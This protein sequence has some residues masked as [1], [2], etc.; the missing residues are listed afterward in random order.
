M[1]GFHHAPDEVRRASPGRSVQQGMVAGRRLVPPI[2]LPS[3]LAGHGSKSIALE[4]SDPLEVNAVLLA[5]GDRRCLLISFD[6][7]YVSGTLR[8]ELLAELAQRHGIADGDVF[9]FASHTHFAPPTDAALP[10]LGPFDEAYARRVRDAVIDL[11]D[12]LMGKRPAPFRIEAR[13]GTLA[14]SINRRRPRVFPSYTRTWGVSFARVTLAPYPQG[15]RDD[16]ATVITLADASNAPIAV[17]WHYACHP[18]GHAPSQATSADFPGYA[19]DAL[20]RFYGGGDG[21]PVLYLQGFCGDVRPN[22]EPSADIHWRQRLYGVARDWIAGTPNLQHTPASWRGWA[23]SLAA[24]ITRIAAAPPQSVDEDMGIASARADVP[25]RALFAG[26]SR[27]DT[28]LVRGLR[29]GRALQI[30]AFGAEPSAGWQPRLEQEAGE[31]AGI[32][33]YVGYSGDVFGYLPL[34]EQ[35]DEGGYEVVHFQP[36]LGMSGNFRKT[37]LLSRVA[38]AVKAVSNALRTEPVN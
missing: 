19:R 3:A 2:K 30:L 20:R 32:R 34:P 13:R 29:I 17:I 33:L 25:V 37:A 4:A 36:A 26:I 22:I 12:E 27:V 11:A 23:N 35:V 8:G 24:E 1:H 10:G 28:M 5:A 16:I 14:H 7:L 15:Q 18:V 31:S 9:M 6:L 38:A 21:L